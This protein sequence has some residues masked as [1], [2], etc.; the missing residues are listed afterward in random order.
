MKPAEAG[1]ERG[2]RRE[3]QRDDGDDGSATL[4]IESIAVPGPAS[5]CARSQQRPGDE[6]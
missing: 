3:C 5:A 1:G 2:D 6:R 4:P